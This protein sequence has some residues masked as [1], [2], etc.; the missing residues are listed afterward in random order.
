YR[1]Y[2]ASSQRWV[3]RDPLGDNG[4]SG[5]MTAD[6][7]PWA[8]PGDD[9]EMTQGEFLDAWAN[10]NGNLFGA[11]GNNPIGRLDA[12]GLCDGLPTGT[13]PFNAPQTLK[14][15]LELAEDAGEIAPKA[16]R[17][18]EAARKAKTALDAAQKAK[19]IKKVR[20]AENAL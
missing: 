4:G 16:E 15:A 5:L 13:D 17:A 19:E 3:N 8:D 2:D 1:Y 18:A 6:A 14:L 11:I 20:D 12:F 10:V 7:A 9:D